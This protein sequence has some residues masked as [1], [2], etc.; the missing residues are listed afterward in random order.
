MHIKEIHEIAWIMHSFTCQVKKKNRLSF[1][2]PPETQY[3]HVS[4]LKENSTLTIEGRVQDS[5][6][7]PYIPYCAGWGFYIFG[8]DVVKNVFSGEIWDF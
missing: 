2:H 1:H 4:D 7:P 8:L 5:R 6:H 3:S